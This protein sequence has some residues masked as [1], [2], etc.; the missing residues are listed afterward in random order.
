MGFTYDIDDSTDI[1]S[2]MRLEMGDTVQK[3]GILPDKRNFSDE[4][5]DHF[6]DQED[7][8]FWNAVAR[9][10]DAASA[11]WARFPESFHM[12]P[13]F[14]KIPAATYYARRAREIRTK[15]QEPGVYSV[16][17]AEIGTEV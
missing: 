4:E 13:E 16:S 12:G 3:D 11:V 5:L 15:R 1:S 14:Q 2:H 9:A 8:D 6:Y 10:F 7:D 17:K